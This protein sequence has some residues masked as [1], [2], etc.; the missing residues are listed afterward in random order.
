MGKWRRARYLD[1]FIDL[2]KLINIAMFLLRRMRGWDNQEKEIMS[3][4]VLFGSVLS[5]RP[6]KNHKCQMSSMAV[7]EQTVFW[8]Y[9]HMIYKN[10]VFM[11]ERY[12]GDSFSLSEDWDAFEKSWTP[13]ECKVFYEVT[14]LF[15]NAVVLFHSSY[16][17]ERQSLRTRDWFSMY[18]SQVTIFCSHWNWIR[19]NEG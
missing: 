9:N 18:Y 5:S 15:L 6:I 13:L 11:S 4:S 8:P 17:S 10:M 16:W 12:G 19:S 3:L 14:N 7:A 1:K 2:D